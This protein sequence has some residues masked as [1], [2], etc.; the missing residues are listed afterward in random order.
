MLEQELIFPTP[1]YAGEE[2]AVEVEITALQPDEGI[3]EVQTMICRPDGNIGCQGQAKVY[4]VGAMGWPHHPATA[5]LSWPPSEA[6]ALKGL[7]LGEHQSITR[8][9]TMDDV[10]VYSTL[11]GDCNPLYVDSALSERWG[12]P[13]LLLPAGLLG[14]LFS[15]LLG[16]HLPGAGTNYLKQK[17][18]FLK[19]AYQGEGMN[20]SVEV[21]RL[22]PEKELVNLRTTCRN[23]AG[24][25][26]CDGV[27]LVLVRDLIG[28]E[29]LCP[30]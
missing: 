5:P 22:R 26:V 28:R 18:L 6:E 16:E 24:E 4:S 14:A 9:F 3:A 30:G 10:R 19:P 20:A 2:V 17:F 1:T 21:I 12:W 7:H 13:S 25:M 29:S 23:Q 27:A 15:C 8:T 11:T